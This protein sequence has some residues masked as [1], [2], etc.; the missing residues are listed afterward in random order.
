ME[1]YEAAPGIHLVVGV[2]LEENRA[3]WAANYTGGE[4]D[5]ALVVGPSR[6]DAECMWRTQNGRLIPYAELEHEHLEHIIAL[7]RRTGKA[8][9]WPNLVAFYGAGQ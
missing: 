9:H 7:L 8:Q 1:F 6:L 2:T 5:H 3:A 4:W